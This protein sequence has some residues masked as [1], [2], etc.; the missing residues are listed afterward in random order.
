VRA[1][2]DRDRFLTDIEMHGAGELSGVKILA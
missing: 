1:D 2:A